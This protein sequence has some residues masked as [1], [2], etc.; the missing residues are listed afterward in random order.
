MARILVAEDDRNQRRVLEAY[1]EREGHSV[2]SVEDGR[3]ALDQARQRQPDLVILDLMMPKVD[4]LDVCRVLRA[5]SDVPIIMVTAKSTEDDLLLG[6]DLGADD[7]LTK[8]YS[9]RELMAR[10]RV[11]MRR[12]GAGRSETATVRVGQLSIDISRHEVGVDGSAVELTPREFGLLAALAEEPGRAFSRR[13]LLDR[14]VGFDHYALERTVD[15]H[16]ANLRKKIE[17]DA[18]DPTYI[19][20]VKGRGYRLDDRAA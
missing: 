16:I 6:L 4:G 15:M 13:E 8:P 20:T 12:S 14:S 1:L 19:V 9:P 7:Y 5:D 11:L 2:V 18:S 3:S 10:V 17:L